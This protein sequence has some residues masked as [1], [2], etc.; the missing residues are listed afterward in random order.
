MEANPG[1][2][3]T[4]FGPSVKFGSKPH[5]SSGSANISNL[6]KVSKRVI[7]NR[8]RHER[9]KLRRKSI[10]HNF[11]GFDWHHCYN[12]QNCLKRLIYKARHYFIHYMVHAYLA[13]NDSQHEVRVTKFK[14]LSNETFSKAEKYAQGHQMICNKKHTKILNFNEDVLLATMSDHSYT[15]WLN[16]KSKFPCYCKLHNRDE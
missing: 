7:K 12:T 5:N 1:G 10:R 15:T 9:R 6:S 3:H 4:H 16:D 8:K 11:Q 14:Q 13:A 2:S